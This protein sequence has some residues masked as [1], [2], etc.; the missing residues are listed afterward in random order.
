MSCIYGW[1]NI[2]EQ[3]IPLSSWKHITQTTS[4]WKPDGV[5]ELLD[6]NIGLGYLRLDVNSKQTNLKDN[7]ILTFQ[8]YTIVADTRLDN[9]EELLKKLNISDATT[10]DAFLILR[11]YIQY[12]EPCVDHLIG[13]FAFI[14]WDSNKKEFFGARD[15]IGI[16]PFNYYFKDG[17][18]LFGSQRKSILAADNIDKY[19]DWEFIVHKLSNRMSVHD[20]TENLHIKKLL[21]AHIIKVTKKGVRTQ[22]YWN[23]DIEKETIYKNEQDY[24]DHF[25]D[26]FK[27]SIKARMHGSSKIS[28]HLSGGLDSS[29]ITALAA[30]INKQLGKEFHTFSYT[31]PDTKD[32]ALPPNIYNFNHLVKNQVA[33]SNIQ[34]AHYVVKPALLTFIDR[35]KLETNICDGF[36][37][38]NN[39]NTEY[40]IQALAKEKKVGINL[41]G[42]LGDEI[43]TSFVRPYYLEYLDKGKYLRFFRSKH[44]DKYQPLHLSLLFGLHLLKKLNIPF[45]ESFF[46]KKYQQYKSN[47][48]TNLFI[49]DSHL[50]S[51]SYVEAHPDLQKALKNDNQADIHQTIPLTLKEYQRNHINRI[52]T[53]R[54]IES[55]NL[56]A[57][58][59]RLEYR[60]P[61][62]D[63]RLLQYVLSV[64]VEQKRNKEKTRL[65]YRNSLKGYVTEEIRLGEKYNSYLKPVVHLTRINGDRTLSPFW[66]DKKSNNFASFIDV[67]SIDDNFKYKRELSKFYPYAILLEAISNEKLSV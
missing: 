20:R 13:A 31:F 6:K 47:S 54:R 14:I 15:H 8:E 51:K 50:F 35:I 24:I 44:Q 66:S 41:S 46:A 2:N 4:W 58:N 10:S 21:P 56:A 65:L 28:S 45:S 53:S 5:S 60:Y 67:A 27:Q 23:L 18:F 55:E 33:F 49:T 36:A 64:P 34:H 22:R 37:W 38:S 42:F 59:H 32:L 19:A 61:M 52:W 48:Q 29:G 12:G 25:L 26:L 17:K 3:A 9:R 63:I 7:A 57:L 62:A 39:V 11:A 16:K 30:T 1:W 43:I 40:E